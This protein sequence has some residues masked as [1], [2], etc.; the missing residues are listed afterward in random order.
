[1]RKTRKWE[2]FLRKG[3]E[4][5]RESSKERKRERGVLEGL[6]LAGFGRLIR[7]VEGTREKQGMMN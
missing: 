6:S 5:K 1:M 4:R 2:I 7:V 3:K